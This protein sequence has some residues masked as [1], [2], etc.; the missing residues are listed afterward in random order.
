MN[1]AACN[2]KGNRYICPRDD[3][4]WEIAYVGNEAGKSAIKESAYVA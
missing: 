4:A 1:C 3:D 2:Q